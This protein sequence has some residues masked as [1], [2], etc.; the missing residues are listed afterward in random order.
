MEHYGKTV[1][2]LKSR[3]ALFGGQSPELQ[4]EPRETLASPK[5]RTPNT[6]H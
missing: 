1:A 5:H 6:E 4:L 3:L 2:D